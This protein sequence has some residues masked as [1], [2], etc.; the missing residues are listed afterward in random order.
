MKLFLNYSILPV[1]IRYTNKTKIKSY[2]FHHWNQIEILGI[3]R[4]FIERKYRYYFY[5]FFIGI[6]FY[7]INLNKR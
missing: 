7:P 5:F 4:V 2:G 6:A 1:F 3:K